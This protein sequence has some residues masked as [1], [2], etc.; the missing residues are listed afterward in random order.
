LKSNKNYQAAR[1]AIYFQIDLK[2]ETG[3]QKRVNLKRELARTFY[4]GIEKKK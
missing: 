1:I 4:F 2:G 3:P